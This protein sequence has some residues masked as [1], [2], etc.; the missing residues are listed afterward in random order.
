MSVLTFWR[1]LSSD[2]WSV[3]IGHCV[4]A[5]PAKIVSPMLSFGLS[6]MNEPATAFAASRRLGF[7]SSASIDVDTS[8]ESMMSMPSTV[9]SSHALRVCGRHR[10]STMS[11]NVAQR[12]AVGSHASLWRSVFGASARSQVSLSVIVGSE[13]L[14]YLT[15]HIRYGMRSISS[16]KYSLFAN[17]ICFF[18]TRV[19]VSCCPAYAMM[20]RQGPLLHIIL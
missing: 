2:V 19:V 20:R 8:I 3:V 5:S 14:R 7:R 1:R 9:R 10:A 4:N 13:R 6:A 11:V 12:R 15:Y 16:R 17:S 18:S